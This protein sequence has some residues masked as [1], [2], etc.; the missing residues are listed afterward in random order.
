ME[1]LHLTAN[2]RRHLHIRF[3]G[4]LAEAEEL[5][6][7]VGAADYP[8]GRELVDELQRLID[9]LTGAAKRLEVSLDRPEVG[10]ERRVASWAS[11]WWA[12]I[13][14][15]RAES[16]RGYGAVEPELEHEMK[17]V[18]DEIASSLIRVGAVVRPALDSRDG[19]GT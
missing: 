1:S 10:A 7:W 9:L 3:S 2:Q 8:W 6:A 4:L 14:E 16:L 18:V 17:R 15:C 19:S 13:F 11:I 12:E 5:R